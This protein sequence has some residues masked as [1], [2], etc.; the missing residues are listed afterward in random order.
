MGITQ[1]NDE[2]F[3]RLQ[4]VNRLYSIKHY[5]LARRSLATYGACQCRW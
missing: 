3:V 1:R 4:A 2:L 5:K